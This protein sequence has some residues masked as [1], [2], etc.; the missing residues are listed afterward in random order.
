MSVAEVRDHLQLEAEVC[1]ELQLKAGQSA[2]YDELV[3]VAGRWI[4]IAE[5]EINAAQ[6]EVESAARSRLAAVV[7]VCRRCGFEGFRS[8]VSA[9]SSMERALLELFL[10][11]RIRLYVLAYLTVQEGEAFEGEDCYETKVPAFLSQ[12][13]RRLGRRSSFQLRPS[14]GGFGFTFDLDPFIPLRTLYAKMLFGRIRMQPLSLWSQLQVSYCKLQFRLRCWIVSR[15][16]R[17]VGRRRGPPA[18]VVATL[19]HDPFAQRLIAFTVLLLFQDAPKLTD[20]QW[21]RLL[22]EIKRYLI[23]RLTELARVLPDRSFEEQGII[24]LCK[25][26]FGVIAGRTSVRELHEK[27][28]VDFIL[29]TV[30][31]AYSWGLT[32][33]LVDNVL[34]SA[35]TT[36]STRHELLATLRFIFG[37]TNSDAMPSIHDPAVREVSERL[38]EALSL[39]PPDHLPGVRQSLVNLLESH[40]R[41]SQRR[42]ATT[43][44]SETTEND[45]LIDTAIKAAMIRLATMEICGIRA[46]HA[47]T[48][49]C[50][51]RS[52]FNQLGD[53]LWDIYEDREDD[54]VTPFTL[55][56]TKGGRL[57]PFRFYLH[58]SVLLTRGMSTRRQFAAFMGFAETLRDALLTLEDR[59]LDELGVRRSI[60]EIIRKV[61]GP[62]ACEEI[63]Q[64]PHVDFDAVLF[65]FERAVLECVNS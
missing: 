25:V 65:S 5:A 49:R 43:D 41:D 29:N 23:P 57:N 32:Y 15:T 44:Y 3:T 8:K 31:L 64:V 20:A 14:L 22:T 28:P 62:Q 48:A 40:R 17:H 7:S 46:D 10:E 53:D 60:E 45:V 27:D 61:L 21:A 63:L 6:C 9:R 58:Y 36:S 33:P 59:R 37:D 47:T 26:A 24:K 34:D 2:T 52:L 54:R 35:S 38:Q 4:A 55:F 42:L 18:D 11:T 39:V 51:V 30:R 19:S 13:L 1:K 12:L 56:L 16:I 50:L